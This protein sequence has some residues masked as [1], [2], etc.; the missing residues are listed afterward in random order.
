MQFTVELA[1]SFLRADVFLM[2][3][4]FAP[5]LEMERRF[6]ELALVPKFPEPLWISRASLWTGFPA[7]DNPIDCWMSKLK[8][9]SDM[10]PFRQSMCS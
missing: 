9:V 5:L 6:A 7:S 3:V 10:M 8:R 4:E 2:L 1:A